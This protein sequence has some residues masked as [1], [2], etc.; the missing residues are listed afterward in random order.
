MASAA[1]MSASSNP[2]NP[3]NIL[4]SSVDAEI[5]KFREIQEEL[6]QLQQDVQLVLGQ[7]TENEMVLQEL[8]FLKP[9]SSTVYKQVGPVLMKQDPDEAKDTV[10]KR[11]EFITGE[12][13]KLESK[14][15]AKEKQGNELSVKIQKMQ[16]QLQETTAAAVRS[17]AEQHQ[18]GAK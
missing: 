1:T 6:H 5:K 2:N 16:S 18:Q 10:E 7:K 17:I 8:A 15:A 3:G 11:L 12:Q 9:E 4:A 13:K 14:I